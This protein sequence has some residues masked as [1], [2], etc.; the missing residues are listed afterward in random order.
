MIYCRYTRQL[1]EMLFPCCMLPVIATLFYRFHPAFTLS[2]LATIPFQLP[3]FLSF[4]GFY[5]IFN[6]KSY[7]IHHFK[8]SKLRDYCQNSRSITWTVLGLEAQWVQFFILSLLLLAQ[9]D[10]SISYIGNHGALYTSFDYL[11]AISKMLSMK[12]V[13]KCTSTSLTTP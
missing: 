6:Q 9:K 3:F 4:R 2:P 10:Y 7:D 11:K 13:K 12:T 5:F 1:V 8:V